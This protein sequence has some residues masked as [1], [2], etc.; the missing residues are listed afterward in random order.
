MADVQEAGVAVS[1]GDVP[2]YVQQVKADL[3]QRLYDV[4]AV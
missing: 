3:Q 1:F 2:R 4:I